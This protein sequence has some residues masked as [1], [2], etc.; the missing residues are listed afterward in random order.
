MRKNR[1]MRYTALLFFALF[2]SHAASAQTAEQPKPTP[3][4]VAV[5]AAA[6][7][8]VSSPDAILKALYDVISGDAGKP[9]DWDR[10]RS[11][12]YKGAHLIP[13][14]K[15]QQG[16]FIARMMT[17]DEY[18]ARNSPFFEKDG[19]H[20]R[21]VSR[22]SERFGN[23]MH[24]FSTYEAFKTA[25]DKQPFLRGINSIQLLFDGNRWWIMNVYWQAESLETPLPKEYLKK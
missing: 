3:T 6:T 20:E 13:T 8:D 1:I 18:I 15:N 2:L 10:F 12:F 17:P 16:A 11:L 7:A 21:E 14:G 22:K 25:G 23:I 24:V 9:R 4:P 19:F 5:K